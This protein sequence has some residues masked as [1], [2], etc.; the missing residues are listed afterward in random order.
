M[1]QELL[2]PGFEFVVENNLNLLEIRILLH[3][4]D[5][6]RKTVFD[7][8]KELEKGFSTISNVIKRLEIRELLTS[9]KTGKQFFYKLNPK[10]F[11]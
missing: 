11:N 6:S 8:A 2:I 3:L 9:D 7:I 10:K 5:G 1:K 4:K